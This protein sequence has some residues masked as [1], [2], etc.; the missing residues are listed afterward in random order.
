MGGE[1]Y[2]HYIIDKYVTENVIAFLKIN[3]CHPSTRGDNLGKR[4]GCVRE[5]Y[6]LQGAA[7]LDFPSDI[8]WLS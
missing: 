4:G 3:K 6:F 2:N 5:V 8:G 1:M 7:G